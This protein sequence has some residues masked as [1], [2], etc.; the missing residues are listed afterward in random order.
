MAGLL[1]RAAERAAAATEE[2]IKTYFATNYVWI[3]LL[4]SDADHTA[5]MAWKHG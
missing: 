2:E 4:Q 1:F 3:H 5:I